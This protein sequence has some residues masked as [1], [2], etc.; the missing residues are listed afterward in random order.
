MNSII[1]LNRNQS[2]SISEQ[3]F[4]KG[5]KVMVFAWQVRNGQPMMAKAETVM[6]NKN[7]VNLN[8]RKVRLQELKEA[9]AGI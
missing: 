9:L 8:Y 3:S 5:E 6:G 2:G 7:A 4:P 1:R